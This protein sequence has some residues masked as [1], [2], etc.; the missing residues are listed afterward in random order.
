VY[1]VCGM[2]EFNSQISVVNSFGAGID[3]G[4]IKNEPMFYNCGMDY[5]YKHGGPI[6]RSFMDALPYSWKT[7]DVVFDSRVHML[8]PGWYPCIPGWHHDDIPRGADGQPIYNDP[9]YRAQHILGLVNAD[10]CPT[11]FAIGRCEMPIPVAGEILYEKWHPVVA[12]LVKNEQLELRMA[13]D[14]M[15]YQL[16]DETFHNGSAAVA[17]G[18]RWFGR[19]SR[20]THR[21]HHITNEIR[22]NA[23][24]YL[25]LLNKG[26]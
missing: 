2:I 4:Q 25:E 20:Y 9:P 5:A 14:R 7:S 24:V 17:D 16:D 11:H 1:Y 6:T 12:E 3:N 8:M 19:I 23:Q 22:V 26:W 21:V 10:I 18:W 13:A 15:M